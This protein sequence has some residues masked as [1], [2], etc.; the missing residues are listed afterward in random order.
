M[1]DATRDEP[2]FALQPAVR[3]RAAAFAP[4]DLRVA[5]AHDDGKARVWETATGKLLL[6]L[7]GHDG[8]VKCVIFSPDGAR[9]VSGGSDAT[10]RIWDPETGRELVALRGHTRSLCDLHF[11]PDGTRLFSGGEDDIRV[12]DTIT[13]GDRWR[14]RNAL[15]EREPSAR[16]ALT[17]ARAGAADPATVAQRLLADQ[18][19]PEPVRALALELLTIESLQHK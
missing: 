6:E 19:L 14:E 5:T 10:I 8:Q 3:A 17:A 13:V 2:L 15:R 16:A 18:T 11:T 4:D 1:C 7:H 9:L 12:W